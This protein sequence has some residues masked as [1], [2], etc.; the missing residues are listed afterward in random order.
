MRPRPTLQEVLLSKNC[1]A[2]LRTS[3]DYAFS[4][5]SLVSF[6]THLP[7]L[8]CSRKASSLVN[9]DTESERIKAHPRQH[10]STTLR[11]LHILP[12]S[13]YSANCGS[14][15]RLRRNFPEH[16]VGVNGVVRK[17]WKRTSLSTGWTISSRRGA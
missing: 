7:K 12:M 2:R 13:Q 9:L 4:K 11:I 6:T 10:L 1:N 8:N 5:A 15:R 3:E 17:V 14:T 16:W